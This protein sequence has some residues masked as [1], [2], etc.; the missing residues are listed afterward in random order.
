M[1]DGPATP[2]RRRLSSGLTFVQKVVFPLLGFVVFAEAG[3]QTVRA[4]RN[5]HLGSMISPSQSA[6]LIA[7]VLILFVI[8]CLRFHFPLKVVEIEGRELQISNYLRQIRVPL[9]D[10]ERVTT[11]GLAQARH[12]HHPHVYG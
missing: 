3:R 10:I 5:Q 12:R 4:E 8:R 6:W 9:G 7:I 2:A 1:A 11:G